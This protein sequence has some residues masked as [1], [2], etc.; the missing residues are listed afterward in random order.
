MAELFKEVWQLPLPVLVIVGLLFASLVV[1]G[2]SLV[3][4]QWATDHEEM[5]SKEKRSTAKP[6]TGAKKT[7]PEAGS[8]V[9]KKSGISRIISTLFI[10]AIL[11]IVGWV[12]VKYGGRL[13]ANINSQS[14]A[15]EQRVIVRQ[16]IVTPQAK[17]YEL[18]FEE[19]EMTKD[20]TKVTVSW[21]HPRTSKVYVSADQRT[22]IIY[23]HGKVLY[24][25]SI[26]IVPINGKLLLTH[27]QTIR[28]QLYFPPMT[29]KTEIAKVFIYDAEEDY[30]FVFTV[31]CGT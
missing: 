29:K 28:A 10:I 6:Q 15:T 5:E 19:M 11:V 31:Y 24:L 18:K 20:F 8:R 1:G 25:K 7:A 30:P 23:G 9:S 3:A 22:H 26:D 2:F 4:K 16:H 12:A 14:P 27:G 21:S 17:N 13:V